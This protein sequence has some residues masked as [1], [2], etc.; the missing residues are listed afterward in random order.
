METV[1]ITRDGRQ[2]TWPKEDQKLLQVFDQHKDINF[3]LDYVTDFT[4]CIQA[5]GA[6]GVWPYYLSQHFG[7]VY[8]FEPEVIN[9]QC[10]SDNT[11]EC[12]NV[13]KQRVALGVGSCGIS[14]HRDGFED[15]NCGAWYAKIGGG[16]PMVSI[17]SLNLE[18]VGLVQ[19]DI[20]GFEK[21]ALLGGLKTI[22]RCSP[23]IVIEEKPLPQIKDALAA[24]RLLNS[25]GY[26]EKARIHRDVIFTC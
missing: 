3:I 16:I 1:Q 4:R 23:V 6:C 2:W 26:T 18:S 11:A 20:E 7:Q 9:F 17:D 24:R 15:H 10:L 13:T 22:E 5:G 12:D 25:I 21:M 19:L 14:M 8:T